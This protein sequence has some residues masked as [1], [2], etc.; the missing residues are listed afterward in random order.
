[1][2]H[3]FK[4]VS[5][6]LLFPLFFIKQDVEIKSKGIPVEARKMHSL[7]N[8]DFPL[9]GI[10][11][12]HKEREGK[13][14][15]ARWRVVCKPKQHCQLGEGK[16]KVYVGFL[17][18][19][20]ILCQWRAH[21][22]GDSDTVRG[23]VFA[24]YLSHFSDLKAFNQLCKGACQSCQTMSSSPYRRSKRGQ[25]EGNSSKYYSGCP[26]E[27]ACTCTIQLLG[28]GSQ[29]TALLSLSQ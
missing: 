12:L 3:F 18:E 9:T 6:S 19:P 13:T 22:V 10:W 27:S 5:N 26:Q 7:L 28:L 1:M 2:D 14:G 24:R 23:Q 29:W 8:I 20:L 16:K 4:E 25:H 21:P 15:W 11:L 17:M